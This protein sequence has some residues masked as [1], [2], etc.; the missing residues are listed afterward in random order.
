MWLDAN[1]VRHGFHAGQVANGAK[2][3]F[4]IDL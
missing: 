2:E 1:V 4:G 3:P